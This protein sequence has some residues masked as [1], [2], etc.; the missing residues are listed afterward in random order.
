[1]TALSRV[2]AFVILLMVGASCRPALAQNAPEVSIAS[3][4]RITLQGSNA[5]VDLLLSVRN[6]GGLGL[7][8]QALRFHCWLGGVDVARGQSTEPVTI[9]AQGQA[10]VPVRLNVDSASLLGV[11][12][13]AAPDGTVPY[14]LEGHAEIGLT[15]LQIP[16]SHSGFVALQLN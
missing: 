8:L 5:V 1:M 16:F 13:T 14:K 3:V 7:P 15:M 4:T 9:P 2:A 12:A 11:L 6:Q 10:S